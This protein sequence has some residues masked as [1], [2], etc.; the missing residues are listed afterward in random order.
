MNATI[1]GKPEES[2]YRVEWLEADGF[3]RER[4]F[5]SYGAAERY[6]QQVDCRLQVEAFAEVTRPG[7]PRGP[8]RG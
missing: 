3:T 4:Y 5:D 1:F 8:R 7:P 2:L 6:A